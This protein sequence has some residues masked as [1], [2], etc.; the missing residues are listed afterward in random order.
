M[1]AITALGIECRHDVFHDRKLVAGN[2]LDDVG[3]ELSDAIVRA[4]RD[5]VITR[6]GFDPGKDNVQEALERACE[7]VRFDPMLDYF[8]PLSGTASTASTN[9]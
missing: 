1:T 7:R 4:V 8:H 5:K 3:P 6:F 2:V 9:G